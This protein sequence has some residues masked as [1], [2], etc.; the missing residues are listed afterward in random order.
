MDKERKNKYSVIILDEA[1]GFLSGGGS[2]NSWQ[3][4]GLVPGDDDRCSRLVLQDA[5]AG[6]PISARRS[7]WAWS[8]FLLNF[9]LFATANRVAV[10]GYRHRVTSVSG[11]VYKCVAVMWCGVVWASGR[12][13]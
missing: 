11:Y 5:R 2:G 3:G 1:S 13:V 4:R 9:A 7:H 8:D 6:D 10:E 12:A